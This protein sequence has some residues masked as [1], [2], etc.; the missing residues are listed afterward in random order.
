MLVYN[1][2]TIK[3]S[4]NNK[5]MSFPTQI[6]KA[7]DV[8]GIYPD[9]LNE[10][11][12][13]HTGKAF[14]EFIKK[15]AKKDNPTVV[16]GYD[17]RNSSISL[18]NEVIKGIIEQGV[19]VVEIGLSST[20]TFYYAVAKY[21]YDGGVQVSASHNPAEYNGFKMTRTRA[22]AISGESGIMEIRDMAEKNEFTPAIEK[23]I[24][25]Q[26]TGVL[27]EQVKESLNKFNLSEL[28]PFK[29]VIDT[30]NGMGSL[31]M[32]ELF[33]YLNCEVIKLNWELDGRF[34]NHEADPLKE[35]NNRELQEKVLLEK[36]DLGIALDGDAD[37]IF[38]IDNEG[39][40][41]EPAIIRGI[42]AKI[43]LAKNPGATIC[44]DVRPGKITEDMILQYGGKPVITRVGHSLIKEK[45]IETGA[46][47]AGE[48]S[49]HFFIKYDYGVF[50]NPVEIVLNLLTEWSKCAI[51]TEYI[52]PLRKYFHSGEIN[53]NVKDKQGVFDQL[54]ARFGDHLKYDFDGLSFEYP[55]FWFNVRPS[56]TENKVRLNLE[57]SNAEVVGERV[58]EVEQ[59]ILTN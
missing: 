18:K 19:N 31:M 32:D 1:K 9:E 23:G 44:Y 10:D 13:Y 43:Y 48:S 47:F 30:A 53:F 49:G 40:T 11:I 38:F 51:I 50:E 7:Y 45:A 58:K 21:D 2:K 4:Q 37:R 15:D 14:A 46:V 8:R 56:N 17:M 25:Q 52:A 54:E 20:P 29:I 33:K 57:G 55:D 5:N 41:I 39:K 35:E 28:K 22:G 42:L 27:E 3:S 12:A 24:V 16:V 34:P 6:Y 26:K 59:V 36:A